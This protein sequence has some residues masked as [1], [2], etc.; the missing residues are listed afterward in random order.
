M[1]EKKLTPWKRTRRFFERELW[2]TELT[3]LSWIKR[4]LFKFLRM[5]HLMFRGF[6]DGQ[7]ALHSSALTFNTLMAVVPVLALS[8]VLARGFGDADMAKTRIKQAVN[9][10]ITGKLRTAVQA[11]WEVVMPAKPADEKT[12][13]DQPEEAA[14]AKNGEAAQ[15]EDAVSD[16]NARGVELAAEIDRLV[17]KA[18]E[19]V[20]NINFAALGG[21]GLLF[22]L[23]M[24]VGV[25]SQAE[26]SFN[27]VW[28][29]NSKRPLWRKFTDY[30]SAVFILPFL[31]IL[32]TSLPI[33][34][35][36]TRFMDPTIGGM[37]RELLE[38]SWIK[39]II[40]TFMTGLT[41]TFLIMFM[42]NTK[43]H[44][45]PGLS[46]GMLAGLLFLGWL[47]VCAW[48]QVGA[49]RYSK[50]YG[51]FAVVPILLMWVYVSWQI[52]LFGSEVSFAIQNCSTYQ[53]ESGARNASSM[54]RST[55]ALA[56]AAETAIAMNSEGGGFD[57]SRFAVERRIPVRFL[58]EVIKELEEAGILAEVAGREG[59]YVMMRS[60]S[61]VTA[62]DVI[63]A[64]LTAGSA[65]ADLGLHA[66]DPKMSL[67]EGIAKRGV[68]GSECTRSIQDLAL[69]SVRET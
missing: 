46:G 2:D 30:L 23:W 69:P 34:E 45:I 6:R 51:G 44:F 58:N 56:V 16:I 26:T 52:I 59:R 48:L 15:T 66:R 55:L 37:L 5:I 47:W 33:V 40:V 49:V 41:I 36:V 65:P 67:F 13:T 32:A 21:L 39:T 18:F 31:V 27:R 62:R 64:V 25:L 11:P 54:A 42:P 38:E 43:V 29:V 1:N 61:S 12:D 14:E 53:M 68:S 63:M 17:D 19:S 35:I 24:V 22:L 50:I 28:G 60:P 3:S 20:E 9:E 4:Q 8:L 7:L 10:L 57:A